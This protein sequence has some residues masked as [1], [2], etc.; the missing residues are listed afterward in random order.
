MIHVKAKE[1]PA[2]VY[3]L[4]TVLKDWLGLS[5]QLIP[6]NVDSFEFMS[7]SSDK[8][9]SH[10]NTL[11]QFLDSQDPSS[12]EVPTPIWFKPENAA[13]RACLEGPLPVFLNKGDTVVEDWSDTGGHV[14][15]DIMGSIFF[16]ISRMEEYGSFVSDKHDRYSS[17]QSV[18]EKWNVLNRPIADE[19][20]ELLWHYL[21]S[22]FPDL[23]R[24]QASGRII[25]TCDVDRPLEI[26]MTW[27]N[28][29][30]HFVKGVLKRPVTALKALH[31]RGSTMMGSYDKDEHLNNIRWM[32]SACEKEGLTVEFNFIAD[33]SH[34]KLD[35]S[36]SITDAPIRHIILEI[37][38]RGHEIGVHPSYN[39]YLDKQQTKKE[40][41]ALN[42]LLTQ[43]KLDTKVRVGRQHFLRWRTPETLY[44]WID[45]GVEEDST[46]S[47]ADKAGFRAGTSRM[48]K[49]YDLTKGCVTPLMEKPLIFMECTVIA[50]RYMN[51]G[52]S[53]EAMNYVLDLKRK[54]LKYGGNFVF[55]WHDYHFY[56]E[57]D[58]LFYQK[59]ITS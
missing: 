46:M 38:Q 32:M 1:S 14:S 28:V 34:P 17:D 52:Y 26:L 37:H 6:S 16:F 10:P 8:A 23:Q 51:M 54:S 44:N 2:V 27:K 56:S 22:I 42:Q 49:W 5:Y 57:K 25:P 19:Y 33:H 21:S 43:L 48:Y 24:T 11:F 36:Y 7:K 50:E 45:A 31:R 58:K 30:R 55:L 20:T 12:F 47:F 9:F 59:I 41:H 40:V 15:F 29:I 3:I 35:G 13:A 39:T 4:D 18:L 53:E